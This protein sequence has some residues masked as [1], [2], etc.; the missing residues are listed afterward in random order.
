[1][2]VHFKARSIGVFATQK[3]SDWI[4]YKKSQ[5]NLYKNTTQTQKNE[6]IHKCAD[7]IDGLILVLETLRR[8]EAVQHTASTILFLST[9][10]LA[11]GI[12]GGLPSHT[13]RI[14]S[15]GTNFFCL[16]KK[17]PLPEKL[18]LLLTPLQF[19]PPFLSFLFL[20]FFPRLPCALLPVEWKAKTLFVVSLFFASA[21]MRTWTRNSILPL[22]TLA[23]TTCFCP[24][25]HFSPGHALRIRSA[26]P[27]L[28]WISACGFRMATGI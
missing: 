3:K 14:T 28:D 9:S 1:M 2:V 6:L 5:E 16:G 21:K 19:Q 24:L 18:S 17:K 22:L 13:L 20:L 12:Q 25:A 23:L 27:F 10:L 26:A 8:N 11:L 7:K 4:N 15:Q